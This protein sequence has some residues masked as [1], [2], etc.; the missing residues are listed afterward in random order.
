MKIAL[1]HGQ[2]HKGSTYHIARQV[3]EN[4]G[5]SQAELQEFFLPAGGPDFCVGCYRCFLEGEQHC[6]HA[7]KVQPIVEAF[8]QADVIILGSPSYCLEMSGQI[9]SLFDHMAYMWMVHRPNPKLF[10]KVGITVSTAVGAG[11]ANVTKTLGKQLFWLGVPKVLRLH[12]NIYDIDWA[13]VSEK[14][15]ASIAKRCQRV[16]QKAARRLGKGSLNL[17]Q[18]ALFLVLRMAHR[19]TDQWNPTD[20]THWEANGWLGKVRPWKKATGQFINEGKLPIT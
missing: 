9:K 16:A 14:K 5:G 8:E 18:R 3:A 1:V 11:A 4:L 2:Q 20:Q 19:K 10:S 6:P 12:Q 13:S 15:K 17:R 7:A